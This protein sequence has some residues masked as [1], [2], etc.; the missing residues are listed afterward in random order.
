MEH[1]SANIREQLVDKL[2]ANHT[3]WSYDASSIKDIPDNILV[4]LVMLHLDI[5]EINQLFKILP[6]SAVKRYW[7]ENL[8]IQGEPLY[9]L[10]LFFAWYYFH[11]KNPSRYIKSMATRYW[12]K[13]FTE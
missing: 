3:L 2:R 9:N 4:E 6:Y 13:R 12:N 8:V 1:Q 10:N 11:A 7:L 5:D